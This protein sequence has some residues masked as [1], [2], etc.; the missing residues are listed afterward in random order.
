MAIA[1]GFT[2]PR[3][4][5][6]RTGAETMAGGV[7]AGVRVVGAKELVLKLRA[8]G[9]LAQRDMGLILYQAAKTTKETSQ[10]LAPV[11][12][13][14]SP[15]RGALKRGHIMEKAASYTWNVWVDTASETGR[16]YAGYQEFGYHDRGGNWHE[17]RYFMRRGTAAGTQV[18][19]KGL[20]VL[21]RKLEAL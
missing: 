20:A 15:T 3:I 8:V 18:A 1:R 14:E 2:L 7:S 5:R 12:K 11:N 13:R 17:G 9:Q 10:T 16:D 6:T 19:K 4:G 21:A